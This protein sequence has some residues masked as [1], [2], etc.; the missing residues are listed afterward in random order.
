MS[1]LKTPR[2]KKDASLGLDRRNTY[3]E[4]DKSSRKNIP[5]SKQRSHQAE[6][7]A[8]L[9][10]LQQLA[11]PLNEDLAIEAELK[12]R[13]NTIAKQRKGFKKRADSPLSDFIAR[14]AYWAKRRESAAS[15][16]EA[17]VPELPTEEQIP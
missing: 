9:Q 2:E 14:Q 11:G 12:S 17:R 3:G 13:L 8:A 5:K 4:N 1:K 15:Y 16:W 6:R 10:P 7:R